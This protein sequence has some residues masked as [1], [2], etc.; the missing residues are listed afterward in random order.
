MAKPS[1]RPR[2][3]RDDPRSDSDLLVDARSDPEAFG[4]FYS[5]NVRAMIAYFWLRTR[6]P[7]VASELA[8]E[9]FAAALASIERYDPAKGAPRQWLHGIAGNQL[10]K[11]WR[12]NRIASKTRRRLEVQAPPTAY[13][14]W[15]EIEAADA[16]LD[17]DR[18][19]EALSRVPAR[20]REAV[21]LRIVSQLDYADIAERMG[22]K[23]ATARSLVLRGL[24]RLKYEFDPP[25]NDEDTP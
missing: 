5:R 1:P 11:L 18:L 25:A 3:R 16:R 9:T 4:E 8:A 6:D 23:R 24:R 7:D 15:E 17:A 21:Q 10:K 14:G 12:N 20:T 2:S 19:A 13:T 22:C